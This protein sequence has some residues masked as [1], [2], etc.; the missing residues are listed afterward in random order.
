MGLRLR[1]NP[2]TGFK[3]QHKVQ[4]AEGGECYQ[5]SE[6]KYYRDG[7]GYAKPGASQMMGVGGT[8][9]I[10]FK[11][12]IASCTNTLFLAYARPWS[13]KGFN[14]LP[15]SQITQVRITTGPSSTPEAP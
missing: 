10:V 15:T 7:E 3:W 13:F 14:S 4:A 11:P 12:A 6:S 2:S 8:R 1:G 5:V 9:T